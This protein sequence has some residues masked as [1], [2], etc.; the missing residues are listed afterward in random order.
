MPF[1][2]QDFPVFA[3]DFVE[4]IAVFIIMAISFIVMILLGNWWAR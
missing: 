4:L 3:P 1:D 2:P